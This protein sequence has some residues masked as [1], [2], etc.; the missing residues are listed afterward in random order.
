[1]KKDFG[2]ISMFFLMIALITAGSILTYSQ[3]QSDKDIQL[4]SDSKFSNFELNPTSELDTLRFLVD[5]SYE[6]C[7]FACEE[8]NNVKCDILRK[9]I[10]SVNHD[11]FNDISSN[12]ELNQLPANAS[13][14]LMLETYSVSRR[15]DSCQTTYFVT[16]ESFDTRLE[17]L[18]EGI[19]SDISTINTSDPNS[20]YELW[21]NG[22]AE[23]ILLKYASS[24]RPF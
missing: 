6:Y 15:V 1:M 11:G 10:V 19:D 12:Q 5:P 9:T 4:L 7:E 18:Q 17:N 3:I 13:I 23:E 20:V 2:H 8:S 14:N 21:A 24:K 22:K 16:V